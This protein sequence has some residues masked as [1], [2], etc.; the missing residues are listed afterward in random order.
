MNVFLTGATGAIG[1][2][3]LRRLVTDGHTVRAVARSDEKAKRV[4]A[5]GAIPVTVDLFDASAVKRAVVGSDAILHLA[6]AVPPI[7]RVARKGAWGEHNRLR[8]EAN[9]HLLDAAHAHGVK[10]FV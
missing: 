4:A 9:G 2:P 1:K 8:T 10:R 3:T 5:A 6:T 7:S